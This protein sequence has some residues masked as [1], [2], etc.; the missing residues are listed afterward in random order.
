MRGSYGDR[1]QAVAGPLVFDCEHREE[2]ESRENFTVE[3]V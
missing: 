2:V 3:Q 1:R